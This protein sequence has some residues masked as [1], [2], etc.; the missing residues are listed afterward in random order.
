M[1]FHHYP[2]FNPAH[3]DIGDT[4]IWDSHTDRLMIVDNERDFHGLCFKDVESMFPINYL[5]DPN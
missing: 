1:L 4:L 3:G 2:E 5:I